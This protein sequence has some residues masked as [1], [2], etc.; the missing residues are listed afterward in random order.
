MVAAVILLMAVV[1]FV[2]SFCFFSNTVL[3]SLAFL[4]GLCGIAAALGLVNLRDGWRLF[5]LITLGLSLLALPFY[6]LTIVLGSEISRLVSELTGIESRVGIALAIA[7]GFP[8][9]IWMCKTLLRPDVERAFCSGGQQ[10][11]GT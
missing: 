9:C 2:Y 7:L 3:A 10:Y 6:F 11:T 4:K 5:V 8:L 1:N